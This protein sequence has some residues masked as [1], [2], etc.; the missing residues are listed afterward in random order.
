MTT[1]N[2][3]AGAAPRARAIALIDPVVLQNAVKRV[4]SCIP[5]ADNRLASRIGL[6]PLLLSA[7]VTITQDI[8]TLEACDEIVACNQE[9]RAT[10]PDQFTI[11]GADPIDFVVNYKALVAAVKTLSRKAQD[12]TGV[13]V[14]ESGIE[15]FQAGA[16]SIPFS[17]GSYPDLS[18]IMGEIESQL[19][20][21]P[22]TYL[23]FNPGILGRILHVLDKTR[24]QNVRLLVNQVNGAPHGLIAAAGGS[25]E[26]GTFKAVFAPMRVNWSGPVA[27]GIPADFAPLFKA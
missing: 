16:I 3:D 25:S 20:N 6:R 7:H 15:I 1:D 26:L 12:T 8:I 24:V 14:L 13:R 4:G 21:T 5:K 10:K 23:S 11:N 27:A 17:V 19:G 2:I 22:T 9:I 18:G